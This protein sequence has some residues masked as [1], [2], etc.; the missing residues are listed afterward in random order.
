MVRT[1]TLFFLFMLVYGSVV[2]ADTY[3]GVLF[4]NSVMRG[5]YTHSRVSYEGQ[6]WVENVRGHLPVSDSLF[7]TPGNALSLKYTSANGGQ[8]QST[9][10]YPDYSHTY[11][12]NSNDVLTFKLFALSETN[13]AALPKLAILHGENASAL[14]NLSAYISDYQPSMWVN[15][16]IPLKAVPGLSVGEV[17]KG[18]RLSQGGADGNTHHLFIDQIEFLPSNPPREKLFSAA[19]LSS[20]KAFDR[21]VNL[22]WELPL[23]PS[24]RYIKIYRS[25]DG[26]NFEAV[27][28]R[29]V[30]VQNAT[31]I[32]PISNKVYYYKIAWVDYNYLESPFSEIKEAKTSRSSDEELLDFIQATHINYFVENAEVNSGMHALSLRNSE[33]T[34]SVKNTGLSILS[35]I[36]GV[37]R[38]FV[39]RNL[40]VSRLNR[41]VG[42]LE[43]AEQY[44]GVFPVLINGRTGKGVFADNTTPVADVSA[45]SFL[46]QGLLVAREYFDGENSE[47]TELRNKI[48]SLWSRVNWQKF[49]DFDEGPFLFDSWSPVTGFTHAMPMGGYNTCFVSYVLALASP[50]HK[51]PADAYSLG[52]G[53]QRTLKDSAHISTGVKNELLFSDENKVPDTAEMSRNYNYIHL[54]YKRDTTVYGLPIVVGNVDTTLIEAVLPFIAFDPRNKAD[55]FANYFENNSNLIQAYSRRDNEQRVSDFSLNIWGTQ[56]LSQRD[57][58]DSY[59]INPAISAASYSYQPSEAIKSIREF[60]DRYGD[61][62]F[63]EYGFRSWINVDD[64]TVSDTFDPVN[65]ALVSIMIENGRSGLIWDLFSRHPAIQAVSDQYFRSPATAD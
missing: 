40:V 8:W 60:Y 32:V 57:T 9:I 15:V 36:V 64:N 50:H 53:F 12:V 56:R 16:R 27:G 38:G 46:L 31:D 43:N 42:F 39:P 35:Q 6:S 24:I 14:L 28:I 3:P 55:E 29:P 44:H 34:V 20:V 47:E 4:D 21:H 26:E 37:D 59:V 11:Q 7:F 48:D 58:S 63:T 10:R 62:L 25:E 54:P 18:V 5:S 45:T 19:V 52:M 33:A 17:I 49:T 13:A 65:Q 61:Y 22:V 51:I 30:F 2:R 41:M 23:T 1:F